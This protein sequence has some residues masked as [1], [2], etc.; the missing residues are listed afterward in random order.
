L[1]FPSPLLL[2]CAIDI[3]GEGILFLKN[4]D[5]SYWRMLENYKKEKKKINEKNK[6]AM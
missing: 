2:L 6:S 4:T 1:Y 3:N 5:K